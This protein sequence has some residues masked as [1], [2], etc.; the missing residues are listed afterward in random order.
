MSRYI[1]I[2][3]FCCLP[4]AVQASDTAKARPS[5]SAEAMIVDGLIVRPLT[6]AGTIVGTGI[7]IVTLPFSAMGGNVDEAG[8]ALVMEPA[9]ATFGS[10]L[11]CLPGYGGYHYRRYQDPDD[12]EQPSQSR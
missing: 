3:L 9:R 7:F 5:P 10:C 8:N 6:L 12:A 2:V 4:L 1:I 11:G